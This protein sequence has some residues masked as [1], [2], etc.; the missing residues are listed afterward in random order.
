MRNSPWLIFFL[1]ELHLYKS[2]VPEAIDD[3][4][5]GT[6]AKGNPGHAPTYYKLADAYSRVQKFDEA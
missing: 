3:L 2:R 4:P 5:E 6:R 1:G